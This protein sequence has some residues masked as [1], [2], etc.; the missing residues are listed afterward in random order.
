MS[1]F[2]VGVGNY[3][4]EIK[5][6][7]IFNP[8]S[9]EYIGNRPVNTKWRQNSQRYY[10]SQANTLAEVAEELRVAANLIEKGEWP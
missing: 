1:G 9:F 7:P 6:C 10:N 4:V 2:F 5:V 8:E 3:S